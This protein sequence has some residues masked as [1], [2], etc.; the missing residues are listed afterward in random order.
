MSWL[1][2]QKETEH[3]TFEEQLSA[4]LDGELL[5]KER[6]VVE[7]HLAACPACRWNLKTLR[8]TVQWTSELPTVQVP[9]TFAIPVPA[10]PVPAVRRWRFVP[11]LQG[12]TALVALLLFFVVAGDAMLTGFQPVAMPRPAPQ[13]LA[14]EAT[15]PAGA[16]G[17]EVAPTVVA[18]AVVVETVVMEKQVERLVTQEAPV[19]AEP[20]AEEPV[21]EAPA[22]EEPARMLEAAPADAVTVTAVTEVAATL[23]PAGGGEAAEDA[24]EEETVVVEGSAP[25]APPSEPSL[26]LEAPTATAALSPELAL[27][28]VA[29]P[30]P[31]AQVEVGELLSVPGPEPQPERRYGL[32]PAALVGVR[33]VEYVLGV[34]L[35]VLVGTTV[36]AMV[37]RR[38]RQ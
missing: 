24:R 13:M 22:P 3:R 37:W 1:R 5:P 34:L 17:A 15:S 9:R 14:P 36:G 10:R 25:T 35:I 28:E 31:S 4:Y 8:Q 20:A 27:T 18:E 29:M 30:L 32:R 21:A 23:A 26:A 6:E 16:G 7:Q 2:K 33:W 38:S 19:A 12:A 11:V